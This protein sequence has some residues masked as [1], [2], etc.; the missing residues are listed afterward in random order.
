MQRGRQVSLVAPALYY[1]GKYLLAFCLLFWPSRASGFY[2]IIQSCWTP[3]HFLP[4]MG[5][6]MQHTQSTTKAL[7]TDLLCGN[8]RA[9]TEAEAALQAR[10][11]EQMQL[12]A[13]AHEP[14]ASDTGTHLPPP[15][16]TVAASSAAVSS[17]AASS[18]AAG[19]AASRPARSG[20]GS[21]P[22][23]AIAEVLSTPVA[24]SAALA[25]T[26]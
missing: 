16:D 26:R 21:R 20:E 17:A 23:K 25:R 8:C 1:S 10:E 18:A 14:A 11:D 5:K 12:S 15:A 13:P 22:A 24:G 19:L 3:L 7:L 2:P 6:C 4:L 9:V